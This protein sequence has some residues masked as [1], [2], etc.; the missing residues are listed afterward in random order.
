MN[1]S[2]KL[3]EIVREKYA[4][5]ANQEIEVNASSCCGATSCSDEVYNIM[6]E[7][8][9]ELGGE[10]PESDRGLGCGLP[11]EFAKIQE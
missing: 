5:I 1:Q 3:K 2:E 11:T 10:N 9:S 4:Q 8:Y 7:D 6:T